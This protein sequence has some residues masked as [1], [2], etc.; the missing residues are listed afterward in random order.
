MTAAMTEARR[1]EVLAGVPLG[2]Y[3]TVD[4][5]AAAAVFLASDAAAYITGT[6]LPIDGGV[7]MG[8]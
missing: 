6:V 1:A 5:V 7:G 4:E 8:L 3:G 2:R